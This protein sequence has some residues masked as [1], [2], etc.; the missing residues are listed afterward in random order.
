MLEGKR[1][2]VNLGVR[3]A[4]TRPASRDDEGDEAFR[5]SRVAAATKLQE[6]L[7]EAMSRRGAVRLMERIYEARTGQS[8]KG[9]PSRPSRPLALAP[10]PPQ[11]QPGLCLLRPV[12]ARPFAAFI[13]TEYSG[14]KDMTRVT[15]AMAE[16]FMAAEAKGASRPARGTTT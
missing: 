15:T 4:G 10:P 12:A 5:L 6:R 1:Y 14:V 11:A 8:A 7:D 9:L 2:C 16:A 13:H 3:V